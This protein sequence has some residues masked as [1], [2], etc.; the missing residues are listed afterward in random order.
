MASIAYIRSPATVVRRAHSQP[1]VHV[2]VITFQV[3]RRANS[4]HAAEEACIRAG[5]P[6]SAVRLT[7][8]LLAAA[9]RTREALCRRPTRWMRSVD[10]HSVRKPAHIT[11]EGANDAAGRWTSVGDTDD[12]SGTIEARPS[13]YLDSSWGCE[14]PIVLAGQASSE[15]MPSTPNDLQ[16]EHCIGAEPATS[17]LQACE[18]Q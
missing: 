3:A 10:R 18:Q 5:R 13:V 17:S 9:L 11:L 12:R 16:C 14:Q 2:E 4:M 8:L 7:L 6:I 1:V 15:P